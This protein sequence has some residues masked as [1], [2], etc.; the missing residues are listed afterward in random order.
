MPYWSTERPNRRS[1]TPAPEADHPLVLWEAE[2]GTERVARVNPAAAALGLSPGMRLADA[3]A[4]VPEL[5][6]RPLAPA[7]D[8]AAL[9][10]L[11]AWCERYSPWV[12]T[13]GEDGIRLDVT[14]V[15]HLFGG[16]AALLADLEAR[17][18]G[19]GLT[20]RVALAD[21]PGLLKTPN[22]LANHRP[23]SV[24]ADCCGAAA[25]RPPCARSRS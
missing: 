11:A 24:E 10:R 21:T 16:E 14:G 7:A 4:R 25:S 3:R 19:F 20:V 17:L 22:R 12:A 13:D 18:G 1:G 15:A 5:D 2:R 23:I 8:G 6:A 9:E